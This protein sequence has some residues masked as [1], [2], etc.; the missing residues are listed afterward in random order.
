MTDD[1]ILKDNLSISGYCEAVLDGV[2]GVCRD[3]IGKKAVKDS[4][5]SIQ[6]GF[7]KAADLAV[8]KKSGALNYTTAK[9]ASNQADFVKKTLE[10]KL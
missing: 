8:D 9:D 1:L 10:K 4:I 5:K 3:D 7:G 6:C 2:R